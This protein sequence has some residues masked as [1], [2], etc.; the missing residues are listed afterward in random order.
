MIWSWGTFNREGDGNVPG[1]LLELPARAAI[2]NDRFDPFT[3]R[4]SREIRNRLSDAL[5]HALDTLRSELF[6][7][8]ISELLHQH[9]LPAYQFYLQ[10]RLLH[11][12]EC[13]AE[14]QAQGLADKF[15][16]ALLLWNRGLFF[17]AHER[18]EA[19]WRQSSGEHK[20]ALKGLIQ[21][22]G[23]FVHMQQGRK[24]S[25]RRLAMR[26]KKLLEK[27]GHLLLTDMA[28]LVTA[29]EEGRTQAPKL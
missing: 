6:E 14:I 5:M 21:A 4:Q 24:D 23:V 11:Y 10:D 22:A 12:R 27:H 26:A 3:D 15:A 9:P 19:V 17:E 1:S 8:L 18:L 16:Q 13:F 28:E 20:E 7:S 2:L 29:L 25:A